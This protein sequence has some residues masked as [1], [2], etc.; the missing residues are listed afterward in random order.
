MKGRVLVSGRRSFAAQGLKA[1]LE[2]A[3]WEVEEASALGPLPAE[4]FKAVVNFGLPREG[5]LDAARED[6]S[7]L[8]AFASSHGVERFIQISSM[9][10]Y[11]FDL[12]EVDESTPID[13][14]PLKGPY[15]ARKVAQDMFLK[16]RSWPFSVTFVR[17]GVIVAEDGS[18]RTG[19]IWMRLAGRF[20][21][22]LG[23]RRTALTETGRATLHEAIS[24]ALSSERALG[25]VIVA[26]NTT[27]AAFARDRL[28]AIALP[29]PRRLVC[30]LAGIL[31]SWAKAEQVRGLFSRPRVRIPSQPVRTEN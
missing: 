13:E 4:D 21:I 16:S 11:G 31:L 15:S 1:R 23:D 12:D 10:V 6:V 17:P 18:T 28:G 30:G 20:G 25:T 29:L 3:G 9:S 14:S 19:G 24:D 5:G 27:K 8:A 2:A 22:L 7:R 26:S